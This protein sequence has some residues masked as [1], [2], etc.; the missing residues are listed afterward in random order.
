MGNFNLT[1]HGLVCCV[2]EICSKIIPVMFLGGGG[3]NI[4]NTARCWTEI[5]SLRLLVKI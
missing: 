5:A 1:S 4:P 2:E 3:Y